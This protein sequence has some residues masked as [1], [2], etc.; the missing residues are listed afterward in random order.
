MHLDKSLCLS[1]VLKDVIREARNVLGVGGQWAEH[2][3]QAHTKMLRCPKPMSCPRGTSESAL[4][5]LKLPATKINT[6]NINGIIEK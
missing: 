6:L 1:A 2:C 5:P 3:F 4:S